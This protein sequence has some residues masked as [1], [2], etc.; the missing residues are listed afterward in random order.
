MTPARWIVIGVA[1][2][3]LMLTLLVGRPMQVARVEG[4][5]MAPTLANQDRVIVNRLAYLSSSPQN[6][7]V[8]MLRYPHN[9]RKLFVKRVIAVPGDTLRIE[10]GRVFVNDQPLEDAYVAQTGRSHENLGTQLIPA[11]Q[12]F[13][14]GDRR[15]NSSDSRHWGLVQE[16]LI[17]GRV[18]FRFWPNIGTPE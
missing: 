3:C 10:D 6:G 16:D 1:A 18:A 11:G 12:Y 7:D 4:Q 9:Q 17:L 14:M 8:V 5:A 13:V 2:G 15:N